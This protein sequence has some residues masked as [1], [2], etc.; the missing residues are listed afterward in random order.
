VLDKWLSDT[1]LHHVNGYAKLVRYADDY[2]FLVQSKVDADIILNALSSRFSKYRLQLHPEKTSVFSFGRHEKQNALKTKRK[3]NTFDFLGITHYCDITRKGYFKVGRKTSAK[4]FRAKVK[5]VNQWLIAIRNQVLTR[6]LWKV[7][8]A[9]LREHY[10]YY[11]VSENYRS[12]DKF[13]KLAIRL[14]KKS[15]HRISQKRGMNW[16]KMNDYLLLYSLPKP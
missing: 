15:M 2:I 3:A 1:V 11:G 12:I 4:K 7:L 5:E 8:S 6:D 9:K 14:A 13:Y 10:E 16:Q